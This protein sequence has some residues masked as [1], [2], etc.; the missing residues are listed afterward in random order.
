MKMYV[1]F[2]KKPRLRHIGHLD[3][4]RAMQRALRR[5][6]LPICFSKGF[7][8][9]LLLSFAAP[10]SVGMAGK[11]EV[12][13]VPLSEPV[14]EAEFMEKINRALPPELPCVAVR[15]VDDRH[16]APMALLQAASF[17]IVFEEHGAEM[18]AAVPSLLEKEEIICI[19]KTKSG[20]KPCN[21]RPMIYNLVVANETTLRCTLALCESATCKPDLLLEA[22]TREAG[23]E[24]KPRA[25]MTRTQ[26][27]GEAFAPLETL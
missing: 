13:E 23:L 26:L 14:T 9:H 8:P 6:G 15:A 12:M 10:L 3:L 2:E 5:S 18:T 27:F 17:E 22:L 19:R 24:E 7:N 1:V 21:I 20:E 25:M 11:R 16:A 4:M